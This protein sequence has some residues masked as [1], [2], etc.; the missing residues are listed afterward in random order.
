MGIGGRRQGRSWVE[1]K[2]RDLVG[3]RL[4]FHPSRRYQYCHA[5]DDD[6]EEEE[7]VGEGEGERRY[8]VERDGRGEVHGKGI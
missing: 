1:G 6:D 5:T 3:P 8:I 2:G 4:T 7:E